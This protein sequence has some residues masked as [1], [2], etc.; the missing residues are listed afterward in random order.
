MPK[1]QNLARP[2]MI[3]VECKKK[4]QVNKL[5]DEIRMDKGR[6]LPNWA[7]FCFIPMAGWY[8]ITSKSLG[9]Q[10]L[11]LQDMPDM[12]ILAATH[13]WQYSKG[14]YSFDDDLYE[15]IINSRLDGNL[16]SEV[17][18]RLPQWCIYIKSPNLFFDSKAVFGFFAWLEQDANDGHSELR[19]LLDSSDGFVSVPL[20]LGDWSVLTAVDKYLME[21]GRQAIRIGL[22]LAMDVDKNIKIANE[23]KPFINLVL[24]LCSNEPDISDIDQSDCS[25]LN[26]RPKKTKKGWR[27]FPANKVKRWLVGGNIGNKLRQQPNQGDGRVAARR[28][29]LRRGHY[30][31]YLIGK[32]NSDEQKV[33]LKWL[34]P[35]I[36]GGSYE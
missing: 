34:Y 36:V 25:P 26:P 24:Y 14:I 9:K 5:I 10:K 32:R 3:L 16:P 33:I 22:D 11:S 28:T 15:A 13:T 4:H 30:H 29:H 35:M 17:L 6:N 12:Q 20:H 27:L 21:S 31:T 2:E 18:H 8:A 1:T 23:I 7:N 19:L